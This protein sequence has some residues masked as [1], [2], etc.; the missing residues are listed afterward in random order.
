[1][2][3]AFLLLAGLAFGCSSST[4]FPFS[5][6]AAG[7]DGGTAKPDTK[8]GG[9]DS[10][11]PPPWDSG[12]EPFD[13]WTPP[14]DTTPATCATPF[15]GSC[16]LPEAKAGSTVCTT[17]AITALVNGCFGPSATSTAC[18]SAKTTYASCSTCVLTTWLYATPDG[19]GTVDT[20]ACIRK[21]NSTSTC[22][23][24]WR[25]SMDCLYDV[26]GSCDDTAGS[27]SGGGSERDDCMATHGASGGY[28]YSIATKDFDTCA[29]DTQFTRCYPTTTLDVEYFYRGAC[30]DGG[31]WTSVTNP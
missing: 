22:G 15:S 5:T 26:C 3:S 30:R 13:T 28:C 12:T 23:K 11:V 21:I 16:L 20:G 6:D 4:R 19:G 31:S 17:A 18:N 7:D 27:G 29:A 1:M 2:R 24:T 9:T 10:N 14:P 8:I 25:C